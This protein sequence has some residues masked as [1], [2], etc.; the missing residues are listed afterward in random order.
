M[1]RLR[2]ENQEILDHIEDSYDDKIIKLNKNFN[3]EKEN[4]YQQNEEKITNFQG[5]IHCLQSRYV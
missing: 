4:I 3:L 1:C 5:E 2:K